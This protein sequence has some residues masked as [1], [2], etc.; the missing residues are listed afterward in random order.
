MT[1]KIY[2]SA[3]VNEGSVI[4]IDGHYY[5]VVWGALNKTNSKGYLIAVIA[6]V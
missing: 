5:K 1:K 4:K 3:P 6:M 2:H